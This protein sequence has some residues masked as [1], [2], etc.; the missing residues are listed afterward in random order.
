MI[1]ILFLDETLRAVNYLFLVYLN[2]YMM[3]I[4]LLRTVRH[5]SLSKQTQKMTFLKWPYKVL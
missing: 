2:A 1:L 3:D 4:N 5:S